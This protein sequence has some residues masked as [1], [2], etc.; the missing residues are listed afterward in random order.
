MEKNYSNDLFKIVKNCVPIADVVEF[1]GLKLKKNQCL[2]P[3]HNEK[4]PSFS[5]ERK[6]TSS[7]VLDVV[8]LVT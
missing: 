6:K 5:I 2:C 4:T 3:F 8:K 1:F 7:N